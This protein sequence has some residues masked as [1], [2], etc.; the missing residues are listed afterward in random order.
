MALRF[1][2]FVWRIENFSYYWQKADRVEILSPEFHINDTTT[3]TKWRLL[4]SD[5]SK[6]GSHDEPI[7]KNQKLIILYLQRTDGNGQDSF[8]MKI[9]LSFVKDDKS[10]FHWATKQGKITIFKEIL[11]E[12]VMRILNCTEQLP[13]DALI[14]RCKIRNSENTLN[15]VE[16]QC[17]ART[18][19]AV[20][21]MY[22]VAVIE[23][24]SDLIP[25]LKR[26]IRIKSASVD[27]PLFSMNVCLSDEGKL[28]ISIPVETNYIYLC[29]CKVLVLENSGNWLKCG[30]DT[31]WRKFGEV[32]EFPLTLNFKTLMNKHDYLQNDVVTLKCEVTY[33]TEAEPQRLET[34]QYG[35]ESTEILQQIS[36]SSENPP[37]PEMKNGSL[38]S[39]SSLTEDLVSLYKEGTLCDTK[40]RTETETFKA[41]KAVLSARS[42]VFK[43]MFTTDMRENTNDYVDIQDLNADT[44]QLY[45]ACD[46]LGIWMND[47]DDCYDF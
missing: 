31:E 22:F 11:S 20:K 34:I 43:K 6:S 12:S 15:L 37:A 10:L 28:N 39:P 2:T 33:S 7:M 27:L 1:F 14:V 40:I 30:Q 38:Q 18:L 24:F 21:R 44:V 25:G 26:P 4:F 23:E 46:V 47:S 13:K 41:H 45:F 32:L 3:T 42:A 35:L 19:L 29:S 5:R 9:N 8:T 17:F 36:P 16:E